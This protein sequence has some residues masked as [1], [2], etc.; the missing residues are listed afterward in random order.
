M[1]FAFFV[2][3]SLDKYR[4]FQIS[5]NTFSE[6]K[7]QS[8]RIFHFCPRLYVA[9]HIFKAYY[10][11]KPAAYPKQHRLVGIRQAGHQGR[12]WRLIYRLR[13]SK[14]CLG[15]RPSARADSFRPSCTGRQESRG[16]PGISP[17]CG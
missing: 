4:M 15:I 3:K 7:C 1:I 10:T 13:S 8:I 6:K 14:A 2:F 12:V 11:K 17:S 5:Y 16:L 9:Q